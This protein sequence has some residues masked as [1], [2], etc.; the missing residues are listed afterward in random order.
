MDLGVFIHISK[1][2]FCISQHKRVIQ[3]LNRTLK[4][5]SKK[6]PVRRRLEA[7]SNSA[8]KLPN[9]SQHN[10]PTMGCK[11]LII[12]Q[13]TIK[14]STDCQHIS[15]KP[16]KHLIGRAHT[17]GKTENGAK[18]NSAVKTK[19]LL[20]GFWGPPYNIKTVSFNIVCS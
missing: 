9:N 15:E 6:F 17:T 16:V 20:I 14:L 18:Q 1:V 19:W 11:V 13:T 12:H 8:N 2:L 7:S 3:D 4:T 10:L 5:F